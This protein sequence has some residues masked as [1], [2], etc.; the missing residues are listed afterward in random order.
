MENWLLKYESLKK[1]KF[2]QNVG[3]VPL[4]QIQSHFHLWI[5]TTGNCTPVIPWSTCSRYYGL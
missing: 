3:Y 5:P 2:L 4:L 1:S